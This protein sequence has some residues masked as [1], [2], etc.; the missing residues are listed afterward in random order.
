[1]KRKAGVEPR[2]QRIYC[3]TAA[4][5]ARNLVDYRLMPARTLGA[6]E[7]VEQGGDPRRALAAWLTSPDNEMFSRNL[8]SRI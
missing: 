8:A 2:E 5:A 1:M 6:V 4:P 3:D 7:P